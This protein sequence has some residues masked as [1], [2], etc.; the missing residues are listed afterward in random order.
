M[1][2]NGKVMKLVVKYTWYVTLRKSCMELN[3]PLD[4]GTKSLM[5]LLSHINILEAMKFLVYTKKFQLELHNF[6]TLCV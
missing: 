6:D 1:W 3:N 4:C 2:S 5:Y